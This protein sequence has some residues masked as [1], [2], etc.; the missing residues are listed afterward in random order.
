MKMLLTLFTASV[1]LLASCQK[2]KDEA[3]PEPTTEQKMAGKWKLEKIKL[4]FY[5]PSTVLVFSDEYTGTPADSLVFKPGGMLYTYD[6][7][8]APDIQP[9]AV[10]KKDTV[11]IDGNKYAVKELTATKFRLYANVVDMTLNER[12]V[13]DMY[14]YR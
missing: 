4:E 14:L 7:S 1:L 12:T 3:P 6:G 13:T 5:K 10:I 11:T 8:G 9:Y 2:D